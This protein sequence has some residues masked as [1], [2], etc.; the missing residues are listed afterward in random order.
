MFF[1][2]CTSYTNLYYSN[3]IEALAL[4]NLTL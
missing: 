2:V 1:Y 4:V 3:D